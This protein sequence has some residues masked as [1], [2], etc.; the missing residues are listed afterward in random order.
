MAMYALFFEV[1]LALTLAMAWGWSWLARSRWPWIRYSGI[2]L[3]VMPP[4]ALFFG[5]WQIVSRLPPGNS[6][7]AIASWVTAGAL[8]VS[9]CCMGVIGQRRLEST[10]AAVAAQWNQSW[11]LLAF[12]VVGVAIVVT[13]QGIDAFARDRLRAVQL[14]AS[15]IGMAWAPQNL[16]NEQ[17]AA[18]EWSRAELIGLQGW[19]GNRLVP[20][21]TYMDQTFDGKRLDPKDPVLR[22]ELKKVEDLRGIVIRAVKLPGYYVPR[23]FGYLTFDILLPEVERNNYA[24]RLLRIHGELA[25]ADKDWDSATEDIQALIRLT[26]HGLKEPFMIT[27]I[28]AS[29]GEKSTFELLKILLRE[30]EFPVDDL[31]KLEWNPPEDYLWCLERSLRTFESTVLHMYAELANTESW[32]DWV[33]N[34]IEMKPEQRPKLPLPIY[35]VLCVRHEIKNLD[36][37]D[38]VV[39][40]SRSRIFPKLIPYTKDAANSLKNKPLLKK[41]LLSEDLN[42]DNYVATMHKA[43]AMRRMAKI[44]IAVEIFNRRNQKLPA[45]LNELLEILEEPSLLEDPFSNTQFLY[46]ITPDGYVLYSV[47][48]DCDDDS[49][50]PQKKSDGDMFV[51]GD[52]VW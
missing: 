4:V 35:R 24:G 23:P 28:I 41:F 7:L 48:P 10:G 17:N 11:L 20:L 38:R 47:G 29:N 14:R 42:L 8:L 18:Y 6:D 31:R 43:M 30:P 25:I 16:P 39:N 15:A 50:T 33:P 40:Q 22:V 32:D 2:F 21:R 13:L 44:A 5:V 34:F 45:A 37:I 52:I 3:T 19:N 9:N 12:L 26:E 46:K 51:D 36:E 1:F 49:G 27:D